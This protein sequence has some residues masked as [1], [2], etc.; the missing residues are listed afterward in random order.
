M[1]TDYTPT[2]SGDYYDSWTHISGYVK[3][4]IKVNAYDSSSHY[5]GSDT[6]TRSINYGSGVGGDPPPID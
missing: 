4:T 1:G 5:L 6:Y 3:M 2:T